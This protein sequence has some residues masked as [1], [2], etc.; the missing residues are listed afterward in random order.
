MVLAGLA[1]LVGATVV[2]LMCVMLGHFQGGYGWGY[3][4]PHKFNYHPLFMTIGL[5]FLY[6]DGKCPHILS[7]GVSFIILVVYSTGD[8]IILYLAITKWLRTVSR[9]HHMKW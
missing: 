7:L 1:Q 2:V 4:N 8:D 3:Q 9:L 6:G 5:I